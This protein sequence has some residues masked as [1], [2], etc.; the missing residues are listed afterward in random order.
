MTLGIHVPKR[1]A[2]DCSFIYECGSWLA[3]LV[4]GGRHICYPMPL[5]RAIAQGIQFAPSPAIP[6]PSPRYAVPLP[7]MFELNIMV[8]ELYNEQLVHHGL[9]WNT[10]ANIL[11]WKKFLRGLSGDLDSPGFIEFR[12]SLTFAFPV[13][14]EFGQK[15]SKKTDQDRHGHRLRLRLG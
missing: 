7:E 1:N 2:Y 4:L 5:G 12:L 15:H 10:I 11:F 3:S 6:E 13:L 14:S 9:I 8:R